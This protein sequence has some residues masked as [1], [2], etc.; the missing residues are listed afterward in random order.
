MADATLSVDQALGRL[1]SAIRRLETETIPLAEGLGRVLASAISAPIDLPP[2]ANSSMDGYAVRAQDVIG[3]APEHPV[4]LRVSADVA[5]GAESLPRV[6]SG[7]AVRIMTGGPLPPGADCVIPV[8]NIRDGGPMAG[9]RL[10]SAIEVEEPAKAGDYVRPAGLDVQRG[11]SVFEAG[12]SLRPQDLGLLASLGVAQPQVV[13]RP[14]VAVMSTGDELLPPEQPLSPGKIHDS[15]GPT[16]S[17]MV[18]TAGGTCLP[19]GVV[20]DTPEAVKVRLDQAVDLGVDLILSSAGVSMGAYD[21]VRTVVQTYGHLDFWRVNIRPGKP[22]AFGDFRGV[23][24]V[25][26][27]GNPVSS[28]V[29]FVVFVQPM[30]DVMRGVNSTRRWAVQVELDEP[31]DS[32]GRESYLRAR[33]RWEDG[34]YRAVLT[35][36]QDSAVMSSLVQANALAIIPAGAQH[37][38]KGS[39]VTAWMLGGPN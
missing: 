5:A 4:P 24:F 38:P 35:G 36:S 34:V 16:L 8:E 28:W 13:R 37:L 22:L 3:A 17:A 10:P 2:F 19:L 15:N 27:P 20:A 29:T 11:Q 31:I 32:D 1:L 33:V 6:G 12:H 26:L 23:P 39:P 7:Q 21:F 9:A 18:T 30:L 14:R 25:G